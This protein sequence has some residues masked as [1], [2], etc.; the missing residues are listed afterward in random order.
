MACSPRSCY[1]SLTSAREPLYLTFSNDWLTDGLIKNW[2]LNILV[3][4]W[5]LWHRTL[6]S[7]YSKCCAFPGRH[8][9][10]YQLNFALYVSNI[11]ICRFFVPI[12]TSFTIKEKGRNLHWLKFYFPTS[13]F[14]A[15]LIGKDPDSGQNWRQKE[16][17]TTEDEMVGWHHWLYGHEFE[18]VP[19]VGDGQGSLVCC[20]PWGHKELDTAERLNWAEPESWMF[21]SNINDGF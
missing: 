5:L 18:Q 1:I 11:D 7:R 8:I 19:G 15:N 10:L 16:K 6:P 2:E 13:D 20:S 21:L 17:E 12:S 9:S 14:P 3:S 4:A